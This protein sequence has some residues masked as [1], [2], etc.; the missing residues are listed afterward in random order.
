MKISFVTFDCSFLM[1]GILDGELLAR[2]RASRYALNNHQRVHFIR[3]APSSSLSSTKEFVYSAYR[4][5]V[6]SRPTSFKDAGIVEE[7]QTT[8]HNE[9]APL[10]PILMD[11]GF[12]VI[13]VN[14]KQINR[15]VPVFHSL[16]AE[17]LNPNH[18]AAAE[19]AHGRMRGTLQSI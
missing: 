7:R 12:L 13:A 17:L 3:N 2:N 4:A 11:S 8:G 14:K 9:P 1:T 15:L 5:V 19:A 6:R 18:A 10:L 16:M